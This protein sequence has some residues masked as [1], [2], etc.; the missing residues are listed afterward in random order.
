MF[1]REKPL[2]PPEKFDFPFEPYSIQHEFMNKLYKVIENQQIGIFESPTGTG[3]SLSLTC[4]ALKWLFDNEQCVKE[5][6]SNKIK[7]LS[8]KVNE[9][10]TSC[11]DWITS[12][13]ETIKQKEKLFELKKFSEQINEHDKK[14]IDLKERKIKEKEKK[15][16]RKTTKENAKEDDNLLPEREVD[17]D[18]FL[19]ENDEQDDTDNNDFIINEIESHRTQIFYCSRT[20][21]QLSQVVNEIKTTHYSERVRVVSLA[22]RQNYCIN[23]S[24]K[25]LNSNALI[26]ERCI[27]MQKCKSNA[28]TTVQDNGKVVKKSKVENA[29]CPFYAQQS[30]ARLT[31]S[32]LTDIMDIEEMCNFAKAE[33]ACPYYATRLAARDAHIVLLPYQMLLHE[34]TRKQTGL[35]I[36]NAVII[37]DEAHNLL[38]TIVNIYSAALTLDQLQRAH[39]QLLSYKSKYFQ[40]FSAKNLLKINQLIFVTGQMIKILVANDK[41][42]GTSRTIR[43]DELMMEGE[44]Y[45]IKLNEILD[46]CENTRLAQKV[47]GFAQKFDSIEKKSVVLPSSSSTDRKTYLQVLAEKSKKQ[48]ETKTSKKKI[49]VANE[50]SIKCEPSVD[51]SNRLESSVIRPLLGFLECLINN[52]DDGRLLI[53]YSDGLKSKTFIKYLLLNPGGCFEEI[54]TKCRSVSFFSTS[55][56]YTFAEN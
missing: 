18:D 47:H 49:T 42:R 16:K 32:S 43:T 30:I 48:Q 20:H 27:E 29:K 2:Q 21:S 54:I 8:I 44:F 33:K 37:I 13:F 55:N 35:R 7:S 15:W 11:G 4:G 22:S 51:Q 46:F 10:D 53:N 38:D 17:E 31:E 52:A 12:Q 23:D 36:D 39:Q 5:E 50:E 19:I 56:I 9:V 45:N 40:R 34:R 14:M 28:T 3:K 1:I 6:L 26:N 25:R 41:N 24:I